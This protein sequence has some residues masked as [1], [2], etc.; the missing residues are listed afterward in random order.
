MSEKIAFNDRE[1]FFDEDDVIVSKTDLKGALTYV[2]K[3][4]ISVSGFKEAELIGKPHSVIRH[5]DMPRCIFKLL[6]ETIVDGRE[7]FAYVKNATKSGGFYWV[8]AHVTP[9]KDAAG[10]IVGFHSNRRVPNRKSVSQISELYRELR[11]IEQRGDRRQSLESSYQQL[12]SVIERQKM[13]YDE[14]IHNI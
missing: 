2:N 8:L 11:A 13:S 10:Q 4:F 9:S 1:V 5:P 7:I 14:M 6:W 12:M 3:V